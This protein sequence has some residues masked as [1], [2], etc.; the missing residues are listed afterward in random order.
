MVGLAASG[1]RLSDQLTWKAPAGELAGEDV[2]L[3]RADAL[4]VVSDV[5]IPA[6]RVDGHVRE[7]AGAEARGAA[8]P[9]ADAG[10][11]KVTVGA[12]DQAAEHRRRGPERLPLVGRFPHL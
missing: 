3:V 6:G 12:A 9:V 11:A 5:D 4:V 2:G 8:G 10:Q 1:L 7:F